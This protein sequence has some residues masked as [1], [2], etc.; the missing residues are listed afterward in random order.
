MVAGLLIVVVSLSLAGYAAYRGQQAAAQ[1]QTMVSGRLVTDMVR[2]FVEQHDGQWPQAWEQ[3]PKRDL[4]FVGPAARQRIH[5]DF[6]ADPAQ[7]ARQTKAEFTAI[8]PVTTVPGDYRNS[9]RI[10]SLLE[11]LRKH[12]PPATDSRG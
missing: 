2:E 5:V 8:R 10:D 7:L 6:Q 12:H 4:E 9:W 3:F 11:T 1:S